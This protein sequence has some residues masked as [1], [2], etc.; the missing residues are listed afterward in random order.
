MFVVHALILTFM[1]TP[2]VL[3]FYPAKY[4][5]R[6]GDMAKL[7]STEAGPAA[8]ISSNVDNVKTRFAMVLDDIHHLPAAM[9][10]TQLLH[11]PSIS[12]ATLSSASVDDK[13]SAVD[14]ITHTSSARPTTM[15]ALRLIELTPRT[16]AVLKSQEADLLIHSDPLVSVFRTFGRLNGLAVSAALSVVGYDEFPASVARHVEMSSAQMLMLPWARPTSSQ[17]A[18]PESS[19]LSPFDGVFR[20]NTSGVHV[21]NESVFYS[22]FIRRVLSTSSVDVALF[23]DRGH[24][25]SADGHQKLF[26]PFIGGPDDRLALTFVVQ[27]CMNAGVSATILRITKIDNDDASIAE[28]V[29]VA[30]PI[31]TVVC[32]IVLRGFISLTQLYV[33][34]MGLPT[35]FMAIAIPRLACNQTR[36][37]TSCGSTTRNHLQL[38]RLL[39]RPRSLASRLWRS[40]RSIPS[41]WQLRA[42]LSTISLSWVARAGWPSSLT[43]LSSNSSWLPVAHR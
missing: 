9:T 33:R 38:I 19:S 28:D 41:R 34:A 29:K 31:H 13:T 24:M 25:Q 6:A 23:V 17:T 43:L 27:L 8:S 3:L 35:R 20:Q 26:L 10:L 32:M 1:T 15:D 16:S 37:T 36:P 42:S 7:T 11:A 5:D 22:D 39:S 21:E 30:N 4:R 18:S 2:L 40:V 14:A 12:S